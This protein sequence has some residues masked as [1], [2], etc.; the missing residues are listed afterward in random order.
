MTEQW[1]RLP[2]KDELQKLLENHTKKEVADM[3]GITIYDLNGIL[4]KYKLIPTK[5]PN[6]AEKL[7]DY[8]ALYSHN[9]IA[10]L[11]NVNIRTI[12][13]YVEKYDLVEEKNYKVKGI[14]DKANKEYWYY[15]IKE[16]KVFRF[17]RKKIKKIKL[18]EL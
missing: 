11:L 9:K 13:Y 16:D 4:K 8:L 18:L 3:F 1:K 6:F 14:K 17:N 5:T 2:S 7:A 10:K 15:I 12:Y